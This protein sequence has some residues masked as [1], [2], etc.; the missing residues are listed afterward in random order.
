[1]NLDLA[2]A[3]GWIVN[4]FGRQRPVADSMNALIDQCEAGCPHPDWAKFRSLPY[5]ELST[6]VDWLPKPFCNDPPACPLR[7]LWFGLYNPCYD[8]STPTADVY[9]CG[10]ERFDPN[11]E[12]NSWAVGPDWWPQDRY[13][14]SAVLADVYRV[15]YR[16]E[17]PVAEQKNGLGND[18]E[19]PLCLGY[20]TYAVRDVLRQISPSRLLGE[21]VELG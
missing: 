19:Y 12:D 1:M 8:G 11:P 18:A 3:H 17:E 9:V 14:H 13:A 4:E 2:A 16:R 21:A 7:G 10:S 20:A 15:A 5:S 6:L